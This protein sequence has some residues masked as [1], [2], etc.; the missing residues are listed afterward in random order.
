M[1]FDGLINE[2]KKCKICEE[3]FGFEPRPITFGHKR[4][5]IAQIGQAPSL[6]VSKTGK[7]FTDKSGDKLKYEW[8]D[9][10]DEEFYDEDNFY[11]SGMSH[12]YPGKNLH[13]GDK[14][15]PK[16]CYDRWVKK[17]IEFLEN[18]LFIIIGSYAADRLFPNEN[19]E[20]LIFKDNLL[21][22]KLAFVL[23]HPSPL[24]F[25]WFKQ[26]P[27]FAEK[28]LPEIRKTIK[29]VLNKNKDM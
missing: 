19:F 7:F 11:M 23:P 16:I 6:T 3:T 27:N 10:T 14:H 24:N 4:A 28:R 2:I 22:D 17:E 21:N 1:E 25:R 29:E 26:H 12:C 15:P 8:Y 18:E 5:L 13:G 9:I 20:D